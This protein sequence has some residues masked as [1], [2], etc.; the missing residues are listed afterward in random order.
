M[1]PFTIDSNATVSQQRITKKRMFLSHFVC[2][3]LFQTKSFFKKKSII[4][5]ICLISG[6]LG[7]WFKWKHSRLRGN[8]FFLT[9]LM[10]CLF[11]G[12]ITFWCCLVK[13]HKKRLKNLVEDLDN[14]TT[15]NW[16]L[17]VWRN[18]MFFYVSVSLSML[19]VPASLPKH[20]RTS[21]TFSKMSWIAFWPE[22][23]D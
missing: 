10:L 13:I 22:F 6:G 16:T 2:K 3:T 12:L 15:E 20:E 1:C 9:F 23:V 14:Q 5:L 7:R 4:G 8:F 18:F 17:T 21:W 11:L 19:Q